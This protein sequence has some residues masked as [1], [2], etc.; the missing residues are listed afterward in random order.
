MTECLRCTRPVQDAKVCAWCGRDLERA[1]ANVPMLEVELDIAIARQQRFT[2][3]S[4]GGKGANTPLVF[5][6]RA[7]EVYWTLRN[8]L[9]GW[10]K[11]YA[12]ECRADLPADTLAAMSR[13]LLKR[14]E[15]LRHHDLALDAIEE[16]VGA[17]RDAAQAIDTPANRA[18][19]AV[20]P[21]PEMSEA[22]NCVGEVRAF[23]PASEGKPAWMSCGECGKRWA[24]WEWLRAGK[25]ILERHAELADRA[26]DVDLTDSA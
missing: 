24:P 6:D 19:F 25:R 26:T 4:D 23:I 7:S 21:C 12:E 2:P 11:F 9:V 14:A 1:L 18:T 13:F 8:I 3:Q 22:G 20:G 5:N 16:I 15:W 10:S 17:V